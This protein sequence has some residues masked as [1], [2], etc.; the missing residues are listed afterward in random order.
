VRCEKGKPVVRRGRKAYGPLW[1]GGSRAAEQQRWGN[2][3]P[4]L[5]ERVRMRP[6]TSNIFHT[7]LAFHLSSLTARRRMCVGTRG[8][9]GQWCNTTGSHHGTTGMG[10][11]SWGVV[12]TETRNSPWKGA[13]VSTLTALPV[14]STQGGT[15]IFDVRKHLEGGANMMEPFSDGLKSTH[16]KNLLKVWWERYEAKLGQL[17]AT[18]EWLDKLQKKVV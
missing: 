10:A 2:N 14:K 4:P 9:G 12:S 8:V 15:T 18:R 5:E 16:L 1:L 17:A 3:A 6:T 13:A 11:S 7:S